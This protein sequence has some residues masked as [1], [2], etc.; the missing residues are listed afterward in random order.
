MHNEMECDA[1]VLRENTIAKKSIN[2][3]EALMSLEEGREVD[4]NQLN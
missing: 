3:T 2:I 4:L 1:V